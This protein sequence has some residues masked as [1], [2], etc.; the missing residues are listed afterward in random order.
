[1]CHLSTADVTCNPF[2][3][4]STCVCRKNC[5]KSC[6]RKRTRSPP[7]PSLGGSIRNSMSVTQGRSTWTP[8]LFHI[9]SRATSSLPWLLYRRED[10]Y[11]ILFF[12]LNVCVI[13]VPTTSIQRRRAGL[14]LL[15]LPS[16]YS[17]LFFPPLMI[18]TLERAR[19]H[20][21]TIVS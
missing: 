11:F 12:P 3:D 1:L 15:S 17:N 6:A 5:V 7:L 8:P 21:K 13:H 2:F 4:L 14:L 19:Q 9:H 20:F 10:F 18:N 16:A